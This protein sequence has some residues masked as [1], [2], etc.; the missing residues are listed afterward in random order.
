MEAAA[1]FVPPF[2][3]PAARP[4]RFPFNLVKLLSNNLELIPEE[5]YRKPVVVAPGPPRMAF[6]TGP[7]PV[8][9]LLLDRPTEFP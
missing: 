5:A 3:A 9:T 7:E 2:V 6:I 4:L 1:G 8:K